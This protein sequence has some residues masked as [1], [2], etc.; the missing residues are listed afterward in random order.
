MKER[1]DSLELDS[2]NST[3]II[4]ITYNKDTYISKINHIRGYN[5]GVRIISWQEIK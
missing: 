1:I 5:L 3:G 4:D 2:G